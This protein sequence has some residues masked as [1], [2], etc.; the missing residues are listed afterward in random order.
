MKI[1]F[2]SD[3]T[4]GACSKWIQDRGLHVCYQSH[5]DGSWVVNF[6]DCPHCAEMGR[7][8]GEQ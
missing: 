2:P 3:W 5:E 1:F 7:V 6:G 8:S 4:M